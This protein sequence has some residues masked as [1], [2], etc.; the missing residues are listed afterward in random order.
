MSQAA[1]SGVSRILHICPSF[2]PA[3]RYG[4]PTESLYQLCRHLAETDC[5]V[6]VL[7]TD[8]DGLEHVLTVNKQ[9]E[10]YM[11]ERLRVRYCRRIA[12]HSVSS[13]LLRLLAQ[14]VR[15][16]DVVH[17]TAVYS[18]PTIPTM[19]ACR[20]IG[21]PLVWSPRG[22]LQRWSGTRR[23]L[24]KSAWENICRFAAPPAT[25]LHFTSETERADCQ[26]RFPAMLAKVIPNAIEIPEQV[27][28]VAGDGRL[29]LLYVGRLDPKKG[30][31]NLL[32]ACR[33]LSDAKVAYSLEIA[34]GGDERYTEALA[35]RICK[36]RLAPIVRLRGF[37]PREERSRLF[38]E[39]DIAVVPSYTENFGL[40]VAEALA[41][42]VPVIASKGTPWEGVESAG[43]GLWVSND[44]DSLADALMRMAGMP[45]REMGER[46]KRWVAEHYSGKSAAADM[47]A[48]Y[49]SLTR[50]TQSQT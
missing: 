27:L 2:A 30:I 43:C 8:A 4:G 28:H 50:H 23:V 10:V 40:V 5:E 33:I 21:R 26:P 17:L 7:T 47:L 22:T 29:R 46:G 41:H 25:A 39:A 12:R 14:Y 9:D 3:W 18:F 49:R 1:K 32:S 36:L 11:T 19:L 6:R 42:A 37:V 31:E 38:A 15:W 24:A 34:G 13:T 16:A 35:A 44:P 20:M 45:L 48:F